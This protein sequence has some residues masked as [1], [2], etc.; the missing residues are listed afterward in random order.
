MVYYGKLA[1][2]ISWRAIHLFVHLQKAR[3]CTIPENDREL[4]D[5][6]HNQLTGTPQWIR[7]AAM[8]FQ[9]TG[10]CKAADWKKLLEVGVEYCFADVIPAQCSEAFWGL[11]AVLRAILTA[12]C[13]M[14]EDGA[15]VEAAEEQLRRLKRQCVL[16]LSRA[17]EDVPQTECAISMHIIMHLPDSIF[18]WNAVRN[19]WA[20]HSE[21]FVGWLINFI[22]NRHLASENLVRGYSTSSILGNLP[23][24]VTASVRARLAHTPGWTKTASQRLLR[25]PYMR[26][27]GHIHMP[28]VYRMCTDGIPI[29][30]HNI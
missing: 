12:T 4:V 6:R 20:F 7:A 30:Y 24:S 10:S 13:D 8:P 2:C 9:R 25:I 27:R 18:R 15:A 21:R 3:A 28:T 1:L 22:H 17:E 16:A 11:I 5:T 23:D 19:F 26:D 29:V 14:S